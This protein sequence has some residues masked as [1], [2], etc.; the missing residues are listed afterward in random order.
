MDL[1][2][3]DGAGRRSRRARVIPLRSGATTG[4]ATTGTGSCP[5]SAPASSTR[6]VAARAVGAGTTGCASTDR[7]VLLDPYGRGVAVPPDIARDSIA[8]GSGRRSVVPMKSVVVDLSAVRLGGRPPA[9][10]A[11]AARRSSTRRTCAGSPPHPSSGVAAERRGTYAGFIEKIPYLVDLG[12]TRGRAAAGLPVRSR[13][14]RPPAGRTTGA[15]SRSRSSRRTPPYASRPGPTRRR[16]TSSATSSRR[17]TGPGS[18]SSSTSSTTTRPRAAP[19][20][21][22]SASAASPTTT[23]TCSTGDR[24]AYTDF[25]GT[26]NTLQ[27]QRPRSSAGSSST[28]CATGSR[29]CTSTASASTSRPCC[30]VTRTA[31]RWRDPPI[32]WEIETDPVLAGTKLIAEAW[33]AGGLYQVGSFV[34]DRW[35]EW[36]GRFRDDVRVV[37]AQRSGH[38]RGAQ[39]AVPRQPG[40][41]R[42]QASRGAGQHQLRHLPRRLHAQRPRL[43]RPQAQRG[44]RRGQP[45]RQ[46]RQPEL[47][48]RRRGPDRRSRRSRRSGAARSR[49][50][51]SLDLLVARRADAADGRRGAAHAGRQQQRLLPGRRDELVR[52]VGRRAPRR[53]PALHARA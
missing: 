25:S 20:G 29:R 1:L 46:R 45:R 35:V 52:L 31:G 24:A 33:D 28:A 9:Q 19:T 17:S 27:R 16:S 13:S 53:H 36:N 7:R 40:P 8:G 37:R 44:E 51:S 15:T 14:P 34:G 21:R 12:V 4:P 50:S 48:L 39:P 30:H 22:R 43:V 42:P 18:R 6:S 2:L 3:F 11:A 26:G 38:G 49:T 10:P 5:G 47:E 41:L 23:T 32:L